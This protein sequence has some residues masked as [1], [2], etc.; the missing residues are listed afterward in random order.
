MSNIHDILMIPSN[1][2]AAHLGKAKSQLMSKAF[3]AKLGEIFLVKWFGKLQLN[4]ICSKN[5]GHFRIGC[6]QE[7]LTLLQV[8]VIRGQS[9]CA[10]CCKSMTTKNI[11]VFTTGAI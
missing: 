11:L 10:V 7:I 9:D 3:I 1:Y 4:E 2:T 6:E 8:H 5:T